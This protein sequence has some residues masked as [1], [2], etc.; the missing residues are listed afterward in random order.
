MA[1]CYIC[2]SRQRA[3]EA[4]LANG[5]H[6]I[7]LYCADSVSVEALALLSDADNP[8]EMLLSLGFWWENE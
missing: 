2:G 7:C 8:R 4:Y 3:G 5:R 1:R 6:T